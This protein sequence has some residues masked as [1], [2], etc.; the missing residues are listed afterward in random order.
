LTDKLSSGQARLDEILAG[1]LR[2]GSITLVI[3][4]PG[5][6]KT[7]LSQQFVFANAN[8]S[9]PALYLSTITEPFDKIVRYGESLEFFDVAAVRDGRVIYEDLGATLTRDGLD[10]VLATT[11][12]L[13]KTRHPGVLVIDSFR[14]LHAFAK[15][16]AAYR[17]FLDALTRQLTAST[18]TSIWIDEYGRYAAQ[19]AP[20][21]AVADGIIALDIKQ[22]GER[23]QRT[24]QVLKLRGSGFRSGQHAYRVTARGIDVFPRLADVQ[25]E[26]PYKLGKNRIKVGVEALDDMLGDG[27][28]PGA[29]TLVVGP[30]GVGKT[31]IGLHFLFEGATSGEAGILATFQENRTQLERIVSGFGWT[32]DAPNIHV[33]SR[34]M[35]DIYIDEW[36]YELLDLIQAV[37]AKRVVIDSLPDVMTAAGDPTRFREWMFSLVQRLTRAGVTLLMTLEV[38]NLFEI[39][40][41]SE[42]GLSHLTD[43]ILLLQYVRGASTVTRTLTVLKTRGTHHDNV[44]RAYEITPQGLRLIDVAVTP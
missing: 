21:F 6:G 1:G 5:S 26:T 11:G 23:E 39:S 31:L 14:A 12:D 37:D 25:D 43:N 41:I 20:E 38:P 3:G 40:H 13:L 4:V 29:S 28:W 30:S 34:S 2:R 36:V 9:A 8:E 17:L 7:I 44:V 27:V 18:A 15:D 42:N 16:D 33:L 10:G 22:L 19:E 24:L 35:V 32:L